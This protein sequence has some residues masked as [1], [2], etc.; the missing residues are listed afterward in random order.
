MIVTP[1][2]FNSSLNTCLNESSESCVG[3]WV[4]LMIATMCV[5]PLNFAG[6]TMPMVPGVWPGRRI[7]VIVVS[8]SVSF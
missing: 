6:T 8:P 1:A 3:I 5:C 7:S 2:F 4:P